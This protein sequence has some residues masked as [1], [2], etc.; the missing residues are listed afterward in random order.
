MI[1]Y[2]DLILILRD[3][4]LES[5]SRVLAHVSLDAFEHLSGGAQTL[6]GALLETC[7]TVIMPAFTYRTMVIP[8]CGPSDNGLEY[9]SGGEANLHATMFTYDLPVDDEMGPVPEVLRQQTNAVRSAHPILSFAG[10]N[11]EDALACQSIEHPLGVIAWL[12]EFDG[13]VLL[14]GDGH[15]KNVSLHYAEKLVGR[16]PF[17]RWA[18]TAQGVVE[19]R[20]MP[21][22]TDGFQAIAPRLDGISRRDVLDGAPFE[23]VPVRDLLNTATGWLRED[24]DA[25]LC[26]KQDCPRCSLVRRAKQRP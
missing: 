25:L 24:P 5:Y 10:V 20:N 14:I 2:R 6:V 16:K 23:L 12:A 9:G 11:A 7:E 15:R 8:E 3:L 21:G 4:G 19:C 18:L 22:C 17:T 1:R 26:S 13:D